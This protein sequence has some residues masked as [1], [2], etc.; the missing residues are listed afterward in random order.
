MTVLN[1]CISETN[2]QFKYIYKYHYKFEKKIFKRVYIDFDYLF[3]D[4]EFYQLDEDMEE[5][6]EF[7]S[8]KLQDIAEKIIKDFDLK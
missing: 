8:D 1:N 7:F 4:V 6:M 5:T 2:A 3:T